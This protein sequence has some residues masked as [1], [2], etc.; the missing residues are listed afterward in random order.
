MEK[1][2]NVLMPVA[3]ELGLEIVE[4]NLVSRDL[5]ELSIS[6]LDFGTIDLDTVRLA[7]EK[8]G[9]AINFDIGLDVGSAGAERLVRPEHYHSLLNQYVL[10]KFKNP[11]KNADYVEGLVLE[12]LDNAIRV[13][14]RQMHATKEIEIDLEN[15]DYLRLAVKV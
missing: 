9:E 3:N 5:L 1:Y 15:I 14:Y 4:A 11:I 8:F 7:A 2:L 10:I 13:S 6:R 12:L